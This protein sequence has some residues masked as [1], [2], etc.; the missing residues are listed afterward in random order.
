VNLSGFKNLCI[1]FTKVNDYKRDIIKYNNW[2]ILYLSYLYRSTTIENNIS[3]MSKQF[4][5]IDLINQNDI[6]ILIVIKT[7]VNSI[8]DN[9]NITNV[10]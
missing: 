2:L 1:K 5:I 4:T 3:N 10:P 8:D 9:N 6:S 7:V